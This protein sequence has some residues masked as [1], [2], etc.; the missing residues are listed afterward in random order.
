MDAMETPQQKLTRVAR[1]VGTVIREQAGGRWER[2]R[3]AERNEGKRHVWRFRSGGQPDRFLHLSHRAMTK[4][5]DPTTTLLAQLQRADWLDRMQQ[6]PETTFF[7][8]PSGRLQARG[9]H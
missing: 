3:T 9:M 2:V 5:E 7:L 8:A 6:G 4:G 1:E